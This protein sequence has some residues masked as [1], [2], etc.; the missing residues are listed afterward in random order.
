MALRALGPGGG[1]FLALCILGVGGELVY[2]QPPNGLPAQVSSNASSQ[3]VFQRAVALFN[4]GKLDEAEPLFRRLLHE[5]PND[6]SVL[7]YLG[8]IALHRRDYVGAL[9]PL[10]KAVELQPNQPETHINLGN[11]YDGLKR[12]PD[13]VLEFQ[14]AIAL[15]PKSVSA[16]YDLGSV[17]F[18]MK[19]YPKAVAAYRQAAQLAPNDPEVQNNLGVALEAAGN[20][21]E[22]ARAY[23]VAFKHEPHNATYA[24]NF[25]LALQKLAQ[26]AQNAG[27]GERASSL[28]RQS[29]VA[30]A[31]A[32]DADPKNYGLRET[33]AEAL[34]EMG[35]Y[36]LAIPQYQKALQLNPNAFRSY[37]HLA[38][39]A[40]RQDRYKLAA[41]ALQHALNLH[42]DDAQSLRLLGFVQYKMGN[43]TAAAHAY[44]RLTELNPHDMAAW[45]NLGAAL[46]QAGDAAGAIEALQNALK[47]GDGPQLASLHRA[48]GFY[49]LKKGDPQSLELARKEYETAIQEQADNA[50][51]YNGLG[52][53]DEKEGKLQE[54]LKDFQ[55]AIQRNPRFADAY[56]NLGV[57]YEKL[58]QKTQALQAY[59]KAL[60]F[61]P[62][63]QPA[64]ANLKR[65]SGEK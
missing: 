6:V 59:R 15:N 39:T 23:S 51:A 17:Y 64:R 60:V 34:T 28:W 3:T 1:Y 43:Y 9:D 32:V 20:L 2:A 25:A 24:L 49:Y 55:L 61:D 12:Y 22:A 44:Q 42:P 56:N 19:E 63:N 4:A 21:S 46:Q 26:K 65:L 41:Q 54:A 14:R 8:L 29:R 37:L 35:E 48:V 30:F 5:S 57:I 62:K 27:L 10:K 38:I 45:N 36:Q 33:F 40:I 50:E 31:Q 7:T 58:G 52:L 11:A 53:V 13:A 47:Q 18:E 16:Y